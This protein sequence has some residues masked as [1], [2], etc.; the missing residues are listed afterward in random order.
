MLNLAIL[1]LRSTIFVFN[2][3]EIFDN[4]FVVFAPHNGSDNIAIAALFSSFRT[5]CYSPTL[6]SS[7]RTK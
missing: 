6:Q 4:K 7:I 5:I 2:E 3:K 1:L